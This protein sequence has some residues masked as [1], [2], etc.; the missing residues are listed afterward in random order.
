[1][2]NEKKYELVDEFKYAIYKHNSYNPTFGY[3]NYDLYLANSCTSNSS[4]YCYKSSSSAYNTGNQ[5]LLGDSG[6]T[7]FQVTYY[8]VY[9][10]IF[11]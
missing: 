7:T 4:S 5:N 3:S 1:M 6:Q 9:Q 10:V 2:S 11:E 8:E